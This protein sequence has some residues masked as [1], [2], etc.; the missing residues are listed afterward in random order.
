MWFIKFDRFL[1]GWLKDCFKW[2]NKMIDVI[3]M[4]A[5]DG[6]AGCVNDWLIDKVIYGLVH[7]LISSLIDDWSFDF[8]D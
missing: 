5:V 2:T 7:R 3:R 4:D 1:I 6:L 8:I